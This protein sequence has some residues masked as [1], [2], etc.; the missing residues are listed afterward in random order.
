MGLDRR[1]LP[2]WGYPT[3]TSIAA[4]V[5]W[6]VLSRPLGI[7]EYILPKPSQIIETV[8]ANYPSL[9][10]NTAVTA[11]ESFGGI[12]LAIVVAIPMA[13]AMVTLPIFERSIYPIVVASQA[14]PKIA[15][16]PLFIV[17][18][19]YG[20]SSKVLVAFLVCFF[21]ILIDGIAGLKSVSS[22]HLRLV[23]SMRASKMQVIRYI[24][25]PAALPH[26]F[27]GLKVAV[28]FAVIGAVVGEFMGS[29]KGLG[30]A[31]LIAQGVVDTKQIFAAILLLSLLGIAFFYAVVVIERLSIPWHSS[32]RDR[33]G[34]R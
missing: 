8:V 7:P 25:V 17:W 20:I 33:P 30:Y 5:L 13:F 10:G 18:F 15:M 9:L 29:S 3:I 19:G 24:R 34:R 31:L 16:A 1:R 26:F 6:E 22:D 2:L 21:P 23:Q 27:A 11:W 12:M 32:I 4:I 14:V 28:T